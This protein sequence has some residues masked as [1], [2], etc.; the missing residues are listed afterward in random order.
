ME[1]KG[2]ERLL[3]VAH[4]VAVVVLEESHNTCIGMEEEGR[5][6][7]RWGTTGGWYL[8][9]MTLYILHALLPRPT[10]TLGSTPCQ[11]WRGATASDASDCADTRAR[12]SFREQDRLTRH[13]PGGPQSAQPV[14][15]ECAEDLAK[16]AV[17]HDF[18]VDPQSLL[19]DLLL[20]LGWLVC[21]CLR[22]RLR[23]TL[24]VASSS[25]IVGTTL[26]T[27]GC[28]EVKEFAIAVRYH[29]SCA[30]QVNSGHLT[31]SD[32]DVSARRAENQ[33]PGWELSWWAPAPF[34][35]GY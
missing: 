30:L 21:P 16:E 31:P 9:A 7:V 22:E 23:S 34:V 3:P 32:C 19:G 8:Q 5:E 13:H 11:L 20:D 25:D 28:L 35:S 12:H 18:H 4:L 24:A 15:F 33:G 17:G 14:G 26:A 29:S 1:T 6:E 2:G 27:W 10:R